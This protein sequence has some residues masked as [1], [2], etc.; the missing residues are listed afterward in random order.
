MLLECLK[1]IW[2]R[3]CLDYWRQKS[4]AAEL[5]HRRAALLV[6]A[7]YLGHKSD[8]TNMHQYTDTEYMGI[9]L[10]GTA[11][12]IHALVR[13]RHV[14]GGQELWMI[15]NGETIYIVI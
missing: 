2:D 10:D 13:R 12:T 9:Y 5:R 6:A 14:G 3:E 4:A 15:K 1:N 8:D 7:S 11:Q